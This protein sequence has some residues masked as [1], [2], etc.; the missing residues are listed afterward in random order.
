MLKDFLKQVVE[1]KK[2]VCY[3]RAGQGRKRS[4]IDI[5]LCAQ[6]F[7]RFENFPL[8]VPAVADGC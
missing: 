1:F 3:Y 4:G 6:Y 2:V 5:L 7:Q 8:S